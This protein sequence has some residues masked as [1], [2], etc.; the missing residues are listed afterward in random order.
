MIRLTLIIGLMLLLVTP[1]PAAVYWDSYQGNNRNTG[2]GM[3]D[4]IQAGGGATSIFN[5]VWQT[6]TPSASELQC[7]LWNTMLLVDDL[8]VY[9]TFGTA[10]S[11]VGVPG[12]WS[13]GIQALNRLTGVEVWRRTDVGN[14]YGDNWRMGNIILSMTETTLYHTTGTAYGTPVDG[15]TPHTTV[16]TDPS[17]DKSTIAYDGEGNPI[18]LSGRYGGKFFGLSDDGATFTNVFTTANDTKAMGSIVAILDHSTLG[19]LVVACGNV[20]AVYAFDLATGAQVWQYAGLQV[21]AHAPTIDTNGNIYLGQGA[22]S[23][24]QYAVGLDEDGVELFKVNLPS[25]DGLATSFASAGCLSYDQNTYYV[26][27]IAAGG[28]GRAPYGMLYAVDVTTGTLKWTYDTQSLGS[29]WGGGNGYLQGSAPII[30]KD[31][32]IFVGNNDNNTIFALK[33]AGNHAEVLATL[34]TASSARTNF[35]QGPDGTIYFGTKIP[36]TVGLEADGEEH[37]VWCAIQPMTGAGPGDVDGNGVVDGLDLTAVLTAWE[38]T[39]GD[40]LWNENAD[41][42]DNNVVDGL[43]LTEVIS[44][45]TVSSSAAPDAAASDSGPKPGRGSVKKGKGN[46]RPK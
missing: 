27:T 13:G 38:T 22:A 30:T 8:N 1:A 4:A 28:A 24:G 36:W 16:F 12:M 46:V 7:G 25:I 45:W 43:D 37:W 42:D 39:P 9:G 31:G 2:T 10:D 21:N 3:Y 6:P 23:G 19:T 44:N 32:L 17:Y 40:P 35:S 33:D 11:K 14:G 18:I 20:A 41:L 34:T 29:G 15:S 26:Q 5:F